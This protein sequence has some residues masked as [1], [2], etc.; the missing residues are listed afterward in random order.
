MRLLLAEDNP[1]N[2]EL[3][4][5]IL[6]TDGHEVVLAGD[7]A[8]A[9]RLVLS[10]A[11]DLAI[12]DIHLPDMRGDDLCRRLRAAGIRMPMIALSASALPDQVEAG[13]QAGFDGYLTKPIT[14][15]ALRDAVRRYASGGA[16]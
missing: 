14:P 13:M 8:G 5:E 6:R 4:S 2:Q 11:F 16:G 1:L 9:L 10:E 3:F 12:L 15:S 7:G